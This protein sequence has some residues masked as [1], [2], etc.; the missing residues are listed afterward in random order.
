MNKDWNHLTQLIVAWQQ[1]DQLAEQQ[2]YQLCYLKLRAIAHAALAKSQHKFGHNNTVLSKAMLDTHAL[3]NEA[4]IKLAQ[5]H[6]LELK[7]RKQFFLLVA[8]ITQ[9]ILVD[10]ARAMK[11]DKRAAANPSPQLECL[12]IDHFLSAAKLLEVFEY[13]YP[14]QAKALK[15]KYFS[16]LKLDEIS[17][18]MSCS[19]SLVQKDIHFSKAWLNASLPQN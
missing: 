17:S 8:K 5:C 11:T 10:N 12:D 4:Y 1:G 15:L 2:L 7:N 14:R 13:H 16:G 18:L 9:Q 19:K 6:S 3:V